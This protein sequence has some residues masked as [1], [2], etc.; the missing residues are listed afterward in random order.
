VIVSPYDLSVVGG[1]QIHVGSLAGALR[2]LGHDV[3]VVGPG[4]D[5][6]GQR[7][8]G[9]S[10]SVPA[11]GSRAPIALDPFVIG[12][13]RSVL[14]D[15]RPDVV[16]VHEPLVPYVGPAAVLGAPAPVVATFHA[17]AEGGALPRL[18][19]AVRRPARRILRGVAAFTAVSEVAA[20]FHTRALGLDRDSLRIVP[21]GV[22]VVRFAAAGDAAR[23]GPDDTAQQVTFLGRLEHRKG[24]DIALRAF[25]RLAVD[26][27][28]L[29]FRVLGDGPQA[30]LLR[31]LVASAPVGVA[32][33]VELLGR[34]DPGVLPGL[35]ATSDVVLLPARGG[36]S[37]GLVLLEA[38]A[39]R[40]AIVA[41]DIP[42]YRAV[43]RDGREA[44][45]VAPGDVAGVA[46]ATACLLDDGV[47]RD[48]LRAAGTARA[49][50]HD[51]SAVAAA[52][53]EVYR[54]VAAPD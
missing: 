2:E 39:S 34:V 47:L 8:V 11:N 25:L 35:L 6:P 41:S 20:E 17:A 54:R 3:H 32:D 1:V 46:A 49:A 7:G 14:R 30:R 22:D 43:A 21:N 33:R 10:T 28:D 42:G 19:R 48:R 13:V 9:R 23:K 50:A 44:L 40:V 31:S 15:L 26:R 52:T 51:W 12:R 38:M 45:L 37:F 5:A 53:L 4:I 27:P 36:E 18:Y 24:A 29:R 16:H